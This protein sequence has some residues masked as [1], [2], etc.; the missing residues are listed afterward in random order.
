M[1]NSPQDLHKKVLGRQGEKLAEKYLKKLG[2]KVAETNFKTPFGEA[3]IVAWDR[4][5][6][7]FT[8]VKTRSDES[9]GTGA[10]AVTAQKRRRYVK[11]AQYYLLKERL[12]DVNVR[13]DVIEV[14]NGTINHIISAFGA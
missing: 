14:E 6:L 3:D 2:Y 12:N 8:E 1:R 7:V 13:F 9:F 4:G 11:I 5:T 10:E